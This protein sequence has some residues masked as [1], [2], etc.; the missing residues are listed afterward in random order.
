MPRLEGHR[1]GAKAVRR[2]VEFAR[3]NGIGYLTLYA[4][5]TENWNR[6]EG[7]VSGLMKLLSQFLDSELD[8]LHRNNICFRTIGDV[9]RLPQNLVAKIDSAKARTANNGSMTL[10][11]ALSYGGRSEIVRACAAIARDVIDG[12][13][14]IGQIDERYFDT[15]LYTAGMPDPDLLIRTGGEIRISNFLLWQLAY[16]ELYFTDVLWPDFDDDVFMGAVEE[17]AKRQRRFGMIPE[18]KKDSEVFN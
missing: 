16:A 7:E 11:I 14:N 4:F 12:R 17:F 3:S 6:P 2:A 1:Q 5:S 8:D 10:N 18:Q 9:T 13:M 15:A